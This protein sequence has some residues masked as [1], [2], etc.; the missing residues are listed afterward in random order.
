[1][2]LVKLYEIIL[3]RRWIILVIF[4]VFFLGVAVA[5]SLITKTY[6]ATAKVLVGGSDSLSSLLSD[7]G[8]KSSSQQGTS[9]SDTV[10]TYIELATLRPLLEELITSLG[11]KDRK[12]EK[13]RAEKLV[14]SSLL[15]RIIA[16]PHIEVTQ[17]EES[18]VLEVVGTSS[19]PL[20]AVN[21]ANGL[22]KL[23]VESA[24]ERTK[25]DYK[26]AGVFIQNEIGRVKD[27]YYKSLHN[28]L[29]FQL[30]EKTVDLSL[31]TESLI[32][33]IESLIGNYDENESKIVEYRKEMAK[34]EEKLRERSQ[35]R[36]ESEQFSRSQQLNDLKTKLN[37]LLISI[38]EKSIDITKEHPEYKQ[39]EKEIEIV[40]DLM[41]NEA[42]VVFNS[43]QYGIEPIY[44]S[45]S[46]L[47]IN[48]YIN[49]EVS[50]AKK[51]VLTRFIEDT[52][53]GR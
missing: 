32:K 30:K 13:I 29:D 17:V 37:D 19:S 11:L 38:E 50:L 40:R 21:L 26:G 8:L 52:Y 31:E 24:A 27:E 16:R 39:V 41:K 2:E 43:E 33:R 9:A 28:L 49:L 23:Y 1:M 7:L 36:K 47:L 51:K 35:Y 6:D 10:D 45:L 4:S 44:D 34:A 25:E 12:G 20:G 42:K 5:S 22:A 3:R 53:K 14:G 15:S 18:Y 48:N 46:N